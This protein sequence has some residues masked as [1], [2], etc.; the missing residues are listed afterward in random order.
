M[1][2][3]SNNNFS[4]WFLTDFRDVSETDVLNIEKRL[5]QTMNMILIRK[6]RLV[7]AKK[8]SQSQIDSSKMRGIWGIFSMD[9]QQESIIF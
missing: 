4:I 7:T 1:I 3:V 9:K 5:L 2:I 6:K 8:Q